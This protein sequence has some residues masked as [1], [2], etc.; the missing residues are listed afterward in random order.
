VR[1]VEAEHRES[2]IARIAPGGDV[3]GRVDP[4]AV[5]VVCHVGHADRFGDRRVGAK[6]QPAAFG[7]KRRARV[8]DHCVE[9]P[10][11]D[12]NGYNAS[13]AIAIPMPP[14]MQSAATP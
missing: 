7:G 1:M 9:R 11:R 8:G 5:R 4:E 12:A 10:A 6:Q 14:P 2:A 3:R 13:T